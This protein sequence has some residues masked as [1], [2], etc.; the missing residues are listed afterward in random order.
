M[1]PSL[2]DFVA[3]AGIDISLCACAL[4]VLCRNGRAQPWLRWSVAVLFSV[5]WWPVGAAG[6]PLV[7]YVRGVSSDPS[8]T[9]IVLSSISLWQR[10]SGSSCTSRRE[11]SMVYVCV[12]AAALVLY[13]LA[14]GAGDWD[15][16]RPGWGSV[17]MWAALLLMAGFS[18]LGKLTLLPVLIAL[19]LLSWTAGILEST[20]L[21]D[22]LVDPWI[23]LFALV[24]CARGLLIALRKKFARPISDT[25]LTR[26]S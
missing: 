5:L 16:Y 14:L 21:W 24:S 4:A 7:G 13:P 2:T 15:A 11:I 25:P 3:L 19:G 17:D 23:C 12:A 1:M 8:I 20:N 6:L 22:Y 18:S 9:L 26:S 10:L